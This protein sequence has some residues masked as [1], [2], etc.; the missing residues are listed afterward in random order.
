[1]D[2]NALNDFMLVATHGGIGKASRASGRAKATLSRRITSLEEMLGV[3]LIERGASSLTL[4]EP[5]LRLFNRSAGPMNELADAILTVQE[6]SATPRGLLRVA[7]PQLFSQ[8]MMGKLSAGFLKACPEVQLEVIAEDRLVDL[9]EEYVDIAIRINPKP[10]SL[11]VG[12]RFARD[13]LVVAAAPGI[14]CPAAQ[15]AGPTPVPAV[16]MST[17]QD[18]ELWNVDDGRLLLEPQPIL[19]LSTLMMI[20]DAVLNGAGVALLPQ[21]IIGS[22]LR[23][24]SLIEWGSAGQDVELWVLHTSRRLQSPKV[25]AFIEFLCAQF[26][27]GHLDR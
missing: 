25:R 4:T 24:G 2:L 9:I 22:M 21:S 6:G 20:R 27:Q 18:N 13:R 15:T 11:L 14:P 7:A 12:R 23:D 1:M 26:P 19:R 3:R 16:V 10:D 17:F 8:M 5:G